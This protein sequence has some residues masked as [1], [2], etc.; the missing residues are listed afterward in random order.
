[1]YDS[2]ITLY[3]TSG[4]NFTHNNQL[5]GIKK[6]DIL[7]ASLNKMPRTRLRVSIL[8]STILCSIQCYAA[9]YKLRVLYECGNRTEFVY[10]II[11]V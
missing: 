7:R 10:R 9:N 5:K 8:S 3:E 6:I 1:M 2:F 11:A 4:E